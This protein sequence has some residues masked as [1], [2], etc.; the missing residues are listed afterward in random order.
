MNPITLTLEFLKMRGNFRQKVF[1]ISFNQ[2]PGR[3][4]ELKAE[5]I[6]G[7]FAS[8]AFINQN[9][10]RFLLQCQL[11]YRGFHKIR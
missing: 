9:Q 10:P 3:A 1:H 2:Y 6:A 7:H 4:N 11:N 8:F 5:N